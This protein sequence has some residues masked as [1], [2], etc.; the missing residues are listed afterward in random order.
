VPN[1]SRRT[2]LTS[3]AGL[4]AVALPA[5]A[6][7]AVS[8]PPEPVFDAKAVMAKL[9]EIGLAAASD[10]L[11]EI[12]APLQERYGLAVISRWDVETAA[13]ILD[14]EP[15]DLLRAYGL[16]K[17]YAKRLRMALAGEKSRLRDGP[18]SDV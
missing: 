17:H 14:S 1:L 3:A 13:D 2:M 8:L 6:A 9:D 5:V 18:G 12:S 11:D 15:D 10:L 4:A 7:E 16:D